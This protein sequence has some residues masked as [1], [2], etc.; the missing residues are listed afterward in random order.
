M[1][2][3][4]SSI[5]A[6]LEA[7]DVA[8]G[9]RL[10]AKRNRPHVKAAG[11]AGKLGDQEP[12]YALSAGVAVTGLALRN[13]KLAWTGVAM[14]VAV[15]LGDLAK[16]GA[17]HLVNRTRPNVLMDE[18]RYDR[19]V[20]HSE[21]KPEQSFPSGHMAC[22]AAAATAVALRHPRTWPAGL[23]ISAAL[24]WSR[25][26]KAAHWPLD[27]AAGAIIG[28]VSGAVAHGLARGA[29]RAL[30]RWL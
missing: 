10:G 25:V 20:G 28:L 12:L 29:S 3:S 18:H 2:L 27:V 26:A 7:L 4:S 13:P 23:A 8:L 19:G 14:G 15:G 6:R 22:T 21:E 9:K 30:Q 17:K 11:K 24:G 1:N 5:A 16:S